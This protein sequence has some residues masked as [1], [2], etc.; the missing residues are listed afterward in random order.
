MHMELF[1]KAILKQFSIIFKMYVL[2]I[3]QNKCVVTSFEN[4]QYFDLSLLQ[5][6]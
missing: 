2:H 4:F 6:W 5:V 1:G 3:L